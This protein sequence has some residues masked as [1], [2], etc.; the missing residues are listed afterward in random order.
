[1]IFPSFLIGFVGAQDL[2]PIIT[3]HTDTNLSQ[4]AIVY[5]AYAQGLV[6]QGYGPDLGTEP[7]SGV[8]IP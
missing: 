1:M 2:N 6:D 4:I 5:W 8:K 7:W 3:N